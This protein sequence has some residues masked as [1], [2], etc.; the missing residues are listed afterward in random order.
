MLSIVLVIGIP[1]GGL[2]CGKSVQAAQLKT[3]INN[4]FSTGDYEKALVIYNNAAG[5]LLISDVFKLKGKTHSMI[6]NEVDKI[7]KDYLDYKI[8]YE[9]AKEKLDFLMGFN[10]LE[11]KFIDSALKNLE[12]IENNRQALG[13][14]ENLLNKKEFN[15]A[16]KSLKNITE[17][18]ENTHEKVESLKEKILKAYRNEIYLKVDEA[19]QANKLSE[20]EALLDEHKNILKDISS[21]DEEMVKDYS[22]DTKFLLLVDIE[23]QRTKIFLG[24]KGNWR[25]VKDYICSSGAQGKDTPKGTYTIASRGEWFFSQKYQQGAKYWV[26]FQGDYLFHSLPMDQEKNIVDYTLGKPASHGCVRL[27]VE[28][29]KWLYDNIPS[30][31][32]LIVQ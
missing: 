15:Q 31:T 30:G 1:L 16:L 10:I 12:V 9:E 13:N 24:E 21:K 19:I 20:A 22:S 11:A 4:A 5:D 7:K 27:K 3:S 2:L 18:D 26:Q 25:L 6:S 28:E 8:S 32:K 29:A 23:T 14:A 17:E